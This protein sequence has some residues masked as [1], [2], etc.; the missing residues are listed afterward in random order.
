MA[1]HISST[2]DMA[3]ARIKAIRDIAKQLAIDTEGDH[4]ECMFELICAAV[5]IAHEARPT[6]L[7]ADMIARAAPY[8]VTTVEGWFADEL[9]VFRC[10]H[11]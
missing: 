8:A 6:A 7:P 10:K 1:D 9:K 4:A 11:G 5:L 2:P 3:R